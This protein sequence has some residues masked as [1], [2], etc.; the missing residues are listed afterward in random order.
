M[1]YV[2]GIDLG[3]TNTVCYTC[4]ADSQEPQV[5]SIT[6]QENGFRN[7]QRGRDELLPSAVCIYK[8]KAFVGP[9]AKLAYKMN[10]PN[11]HSFSSIKRRMGSSWAKLI[12]NKPWTPE[13]ISACILATVRKELETKY[14]SLPEKLVITVPASFGTEARRAT[15]AAAAI[16][17]FAPE[18]TSLF[19]EPTAAL[20]NALIENTQN[21]DELNQTLHM[22]IDIGGGTQDVSLLKMSYQDGKLSFDI[23]GQSRLNELAGD[24]FDFNIAGLLLYRWEQ[25]FQCSFDDWNE[26]EN[27]LS[28]LQKIFVTELLSEA[29]KLKTKLSTKM[30]QSPR[31]GW[32]SAEETVV[33]PDTPK[34]AWSYSFTG[35]DLINSLREFFPFSGDPTD[36]LQE[37]GFYRAI[38]E[39]LN[40]AN[41][42][43]DYPL[44]TF[45]IDKVWL[46]GGSAQLP[47]V[48]FAV[49]KLTHQK[50]TLIN[51][52]MYAVAKGACRYALIKDS[53][54]IS[55][56]ERMFDGIY[57]QVATGQFLCLVSPKNEIPIHKSYQNIL[58]TPEISRGIVVHLFYGATM[59]IEQGEILKSAAKLSPLIRKS[60]FFDELLPVNHPISIEVDVNEN[61][62]VQLQFLT[63]LN[64]RH[65]EGKVSV[66]VGGNHSFSEKGD[67]II[68][69]QINIGIDSHDT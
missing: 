33:L 66:N 22:I 55:L 53:A 17:G 11:V 69:P 43:L 64:G 40:S 1:K 38:Q 26:K 31:S 54:T 52:C 48:P 20:L 27:K 46:A 13:K 41:S 4:T 45:D 56:R 58:K 49:Q 57:I 16:A 36:R 62:N 5:L 8:N 12:N 35:L 44:E 21:K 2:A 10:I 59:N 65:L 68:L 19:D 63:S 3:T 30:N 24:D 37:F 60:V 51:D 39:C 7:S 42:I 9:I 23:L 6:M 67:D 15:L 28:K 25:H 50:P 61:R 32:V 14:S 47:L 18:T 29:S 34:G